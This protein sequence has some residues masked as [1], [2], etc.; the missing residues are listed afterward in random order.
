MLLAAV[1]VA[2]ALV[3]GAT[4][5]D[6]DGP[7]ELLGADQS[8][9]EGADPAEADASEPTASGWAPPA[10]AEL[11]PG[12]VAL[13]A[14]DVASLGTSAA[15]TLVATAPVVVT[16]SSSTGPEADE[17]VELAESLHAPLLFLDASTADGASGSDETSTASP[18]AGPSG[19]SA[20]PS[21]EPTAD[22]AASPTELLAGWSTAHVVAV[23][24]PPETSATVHAVTVED[25]GDGATSAPA[26][27]TLPEAIE[28]MVADAEAAPSPEPAPGLVVVV[29]TAPDD[30][31]ADDEGAEAEDEPSAD[32]SEDAAT[33]AASSAPDDDTDD[34]TDDELVDVPADLRTT[35]AVLGIEAVGWGSADPRTD[36]RVRDVTAQAETTLLAVADDQWPDGI[37]MSTVEPDW[38]ALFTIAADAPELN[39][40]GLVLFPDRTFIAT[41]GNPSGPALGVLGERDVE[42]SIAFVEELAAEYEGLFGDSQ[43]QPAFELITTIAAADAGDDGDYSR[44]EDL[45]LVTEWVD[46]A[47]EA[48]LYVVLDLQPGRTDFLTQAQTLEDLLRRPNVGLALDPEWR[49]EPDEVHL[50][51]IGTVETAEV[52]EVADW[53]AELVRDE[54]LPQKLL[55]VHNFRLSMLSDR[56]DLRFH[57]EVATMVHVDGQGAQDDKDAT[58]ASITGAGPDE[59]WWG[60]KNFYDEDV[61]E[62]RSPE[63][64]AEVEPTPHFI[65]YQ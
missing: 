42:G 22:A 18:S 26:N 29:R 11:E 14:T 5:L 10:L 54:V 61:P 17:A 12:V 9:D 20:A 46:A 32:P 6:Q 58:Y 2:G 3:W 37:P 35:L 13:S 23:G 64:T 28:A 60:W 50:Q 7:S 56:E 51:Q 39:G 55:I 4:N 53:L 63:D 33:E 57:P 24:T 25:S 41:Y 49:L 16:S 31:G 52:N 65:S 43:V 38:P 47:T 59:L 30:E 34:D 8:S 19:G 36:D 48:G 45:D 44:P 1:L 40:G 21:S 27:V 15:A 62:I